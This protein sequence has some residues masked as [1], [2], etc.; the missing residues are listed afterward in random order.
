IGGKLVCYNAGSGGEEWQLPLEGDLAKN[1]GRLA[2]PPVYVGGSLIL[3]ASNARVHRIEARTG[4]ILKTWNTGAQHH[5]PPMVMH[6]QIWTPT[7]QGA[8]KVIETHDPQLTGWPC[9]GGNA[10]RDNRPQQISD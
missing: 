8:L 2:A 3:A 7:N 1:G 4:R 5:S 10:Q 6:G 9:W